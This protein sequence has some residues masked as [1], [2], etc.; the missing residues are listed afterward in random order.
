MS[1]EK[2]SLADLNG[3]GSRRE[4]GE[5]VRQN[6]GHSCLYKYVVVVV[7]LLSHD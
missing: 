1:E 3:L 6:L 4:N 2:G 7:W 5:T